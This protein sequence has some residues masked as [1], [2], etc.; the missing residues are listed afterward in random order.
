MFADVQSANPECTSLYKTV[1]PS[2]PNTH[3]VSWPEKAFISFTSGVQWSEGLAEEWAFGVASPGSR[4]S[5]TVGR[6]G[7]NSWLGA[8]PELLDL[9]PASLLV[10]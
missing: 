3:S 7:D 9:V 5:R 1:L 2:L 6:E 4:L 10:Y 8:T